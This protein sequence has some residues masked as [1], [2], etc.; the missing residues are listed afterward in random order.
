MGE[1]EEEKRGKKEPA[2][3]DRLHFVLQSLAGVI[4]TVIATQPGPRLFLRDGLWNEE[5]FSRKIAK[6]RILID[7]GELCPKSKGI[8]NGLGVI[9]TISIVMR[10]WMN[11]PTLTNSDSCTKTW[12]GKRIFK[13]QQKA[14]LSSREV[15]WRG[16][17]SPCM[18]R[19]PAGT[20]SLLLPP[21]RPATCPTRLQLRWVAQH[22]SVLW[23]NV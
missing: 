15:S 4:L 9:T 3:R 22:S 19:A 5:S 10:L 6:G 12:M 11:G 18:P 1:L 21:A 8:L 2:G 13:Q 14:K 16:S 20:C 23:G 17:T 7:E